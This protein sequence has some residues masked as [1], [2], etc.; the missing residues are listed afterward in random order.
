MCSFREFQAYS[1]VFDLSKFYPECVIRS[2]HRVET[3]VSYSLRP[4]ISR[5]D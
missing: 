1:L 3:K 2:V 4:S 5:V